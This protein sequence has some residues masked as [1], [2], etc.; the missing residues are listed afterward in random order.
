MH[1]RN[2]FFFLYFVQVL[3][4]IFNDFL[5]FCRR[6]DFHLYYTQKAV[7]ISEFMHIIDLQFVR[8]YFLCFLGL[9][10]CKLITSGGH[11]TKYKEKVQC[12]GIIIRQEAKQLLGEK[13]KRKNKNTSAVYRGAAVKSIKTFMLERKYLSNIMCRYKKKQIMLQ[14]QLCLI[15]R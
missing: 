7:S 14:R 5:S 13:D 12:K 10:S 8:F 1:I 3:I 15:Q 9:S 2:I 4:V 11:R 6:Q